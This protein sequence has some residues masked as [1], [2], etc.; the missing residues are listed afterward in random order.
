MSPDSASSAPSMSGTVS[1]RSHWLLA[2]C[3]L[4]IL[5]SAW[6][7]SLIQTSWGRVQLTEVRFPTQNGQWLAGDLYR[8]RT[9]TEKTPAPLVVVVPG[10]QR[11]KEALSNIAIELARRGIVVI[12]IDPYAQGNSSASESRRSATTEGYGLFAVIEYAA[13]TEL[14]NYV[15]KARIG[16]TGHSAGGNAVVLAA[17]RFGRQA[18]RANEPSKLHSAFVSGYLLAFTEENLRGVRSNLGSSY[19]LY[20]EGAYRNELENGD[21]RRAPEALRLINTATGDGFTPVAEV[22]SGRYYGDPAVRG[23]RVMH[24]E[25]LLHPLQPYS[26]GETAHQLAYFERAFGLS[27][28]LPHTDQVWYWKELFTA[29]CLVAAF[30]ALVPFARLLLEGVAWFRPLQHPLPPPQPRH[31]SAALFWGLLLTGAVIACVSYIPMTELSQKLFVE[32]S[33]RAQTWFFPQRMNNAVM[34]WALLNGA[35]GFGLFYLGYR[36]NRTRGV[37]R[38]MLGVATN[39]GELLR[40]AVLAG[41]LFASFFLLL[42][43]VYY[44]FHVDFRLLFFGARVFQPATM[45]LLLMYAPAFFVF[46]LQNSLRVNGAMRREGVPEWRSMLL[47]GFANSAG[48]LLILVVQYVCL[49]VTGTVYWTDGWLYI[50]LLFAVVPMMFVLPYFNRFF[51]RLTGRIYLGPL[52]TC[53]IF[54][55]MLVANTVCYLPF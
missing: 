11:S 12:S 32:A 35:V 49:A 52:V 48:L 3:L 44:F 45:V 31:G 6:F 13:D 16:A 41:A 33:G 14:L 5:V 53:P 20:D 15:D 10:F 34:L 19:G 42:F 40:T 1:R 51:F 24:N 30:V 25:P 8:P 43:T 54:I 47:A 55:M 26:A 46:F 28:E 7:A 2:G 17:R 27:W 4:T 37:T 36:V 18:A 23:L 29:L 39:A 50:N 9:A 22:E 38:E 21:M